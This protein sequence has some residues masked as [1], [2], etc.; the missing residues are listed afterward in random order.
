MKLDELTETID[1]YVVKISINHD[2]NMGAPWE[3]HDGHGIVSDWESRDKLPSELVLCEDMRSSRYYDFKGTLKL[4]KRDGWGLNDDA[5]AKLAKRI[6]R[7]PTAK[8]IL[9]EAVQRD[10]EYLQGWCNDDWC[11][12]GYTTEIETPNGETIEG[13]SC[14]GFDDKDYMVSEALSH[15]KGEIERHKK[16]M[17]ETA[18][19]EC[20]P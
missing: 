16:T 8:E 4:A 13:D 2:E 7:K 11:W 12:L 19:A 1:G 6:G 10:F 17:R 3:E 9:V 15:A 18:I 5:K 20:V 14:W